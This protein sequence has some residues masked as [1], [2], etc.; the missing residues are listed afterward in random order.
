VS[1]SKPVALTLL[2]FYSL[3]TYA[4]EKPGQ[5]TGRVVDSKN[6]AISDV[7][8]QLLNHDNKAVS[9]RVFTDSTGT[10]L[11]NNLNLG[12]YRL[13][14]SYLGL[15]TLL[16]NFIITAEKPKVSLD[17]IILEDSRSLNTVEIKGAVNPV[18]VRKDTTEYNAKYYKTRE[19]AMLEDLLKRLP[20]VQVDR[21]GKVTTQGEVINRI[22]LNGKEFFTGDPLKATKNIPVAIINKVQV[23]DQKSE[24]AQ[25][26]GIDFGKKTKMINIITDEDKNKGF[27]GKQTAGYGTNDRYEVKLNGNYFDDQEQITLLGAL[28][29]INSNASAGQVTPG[30]SSTIQ[31]GIN[32]SNRF[33]KGTQLNFSYDL[34]H[35]DQNLTKVSETETVYGSFTQINSNNSIARDLRDNHRFNFLLYTNISPTVNIRIQPSVSL[36]DYQNSMLM[37]YSNTSVSSLIN[38]NQDQNRIGK[39]PVGSNTLHLSKKFAK[40]GRSLSVKVVSSIN[41]TNEDFYTLRNE[42]LKNSPDEDQPSELENI[43]QK[44]LNEEKR[45]NNSAT[46]LYTEPISNNNLIGLSYTNGYSTSIADRLTFDFNPITNEYDQPNQQFT[47]LFKNET[48]T[49][50][51]GLNF[52]HSGKK[53][54]LQINVNAQ[55]T[56]QKNRVK[57]QRFFN[58]VPAAELSFQFTDSKRMS[59]RYEGKINQPDLSQVQPGSDNTDNNNQQFGN[60]ALKPSYTHNVNLSFNN[61]ITENN[62]VIFINANLSQT[63]E[64]I[65]P[66]VSYDT[67]S[68]KNIIQFVNASKSYS[69]MITG[70]YGFSI[71]D[72]N[73][74]SLNIGL[75]TLL[76]SMSNFSN[77]QNNITNTW[78]VNNNYRLSGQFDDFD[79][80]INAAL[81]YNLLTYSIRKENNQQY[82]NYTAGID[83]SYLF[84]KNIRFTANVNYNKTDGGGP[85]FDLTVIPVNLSLSK[86][87]LKSKAAMIS[88]SVNDLFDQN[89]GINRSTNEFSVTD[90]NFNV[91]SRYCMLSLSYAISKF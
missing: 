90:S 81:T 75:N 68:R 10:Y 46:I 13:K 79:V 30:I 59:M 77:G 84:P 20:G 73:S 7:S 60:A 89:K 83:A 40:V 41:K 69:G 23:I 71:A 61:F 1:I 72:D 52:A 27:F 37:D 24:Q 3:L 65:V 26:S 42:E 33:S 11:L 67:T 54:N 45:I 12:N 55:L 85:G 70:L 14:V 31:S 66:S 6:I 64:D 21:D 53:Y 49:Q 50:L 22:T 4:Q 34:D 88:F 18:R 32:Y 57:N 15:E 63:G 48:F 35:S 44:L 43:A 29:N 2:I 19:E 80:N 8:I 58:V 82:L 86:Q 56:N 39:T 17:N 28:S 87:F 78:A 16:V 9:T 91:L 47:S 36:N 25:L 38:G 5:V 74:L 51:T 76:N 62:K